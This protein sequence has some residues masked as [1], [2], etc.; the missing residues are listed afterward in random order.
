MQLGVIAFWVFIVVLSLAL[1]LVSYLN[2]REV[3]KTLRFAIERGVALDAE[4]LASLKDRASG[5]TPAYL[6]AAGI[7]LLAGALGVAAFGVIIAS[8]EP[9]TLVPLLG[10]AVLFAFIAGGML[11]SG[12]WLLRRRK[13]DAA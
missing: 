3:E 8:E 11:A 2:R 4:L 6:I 12:V 1:T 5:R 7:V 10:I 9:D 13:L